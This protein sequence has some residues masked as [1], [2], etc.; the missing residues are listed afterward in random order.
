MPF[1]AL[2]DAEKELVRQFQ[3]QHGKKSGAA[4]RALIMRGTDPEEAKARALSLPK[5]ENNADDGFT[6][7]KPKRKYTRKQTVMPSI[8]EESEQKPEFKPEAK[9]RG[10]KP[11]QELKED[12]ELII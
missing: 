9:K 4:C 5:I 12:V 7:V 6:E 3:E 1:R 8:T 10:R 11:K 2:S